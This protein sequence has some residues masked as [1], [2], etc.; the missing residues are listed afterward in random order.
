MTFFARS[1]TSSY[2]SQEKQSPQ[3]RP[4]GKSALL[5]QYSQLSAC[6]I[7]PAVP[8]PAWCSVLWPG[9]VR[10]QPS[11]RAG[12]RR[13]ALPVE[14]PQLSEQPQVSLLDR[15]SC[16]AMVRKCVTLW[17]LLSGFTRWKGAYKFWHYPMEMSVLQLL[18]SSFVLILSSPPQVPTAEGWEPKN[19]GVSC[20]NST[21]SCV[22]VRPALCRLCS[23]RR[24]TRRK[25]CLV[26]CV[27][28]AKDLLRWF[29]VWLRLFCKPFEIIY[30]SFQSFLIFFDIWDAMW[31]LEKQ[32]R[33]TC[34]I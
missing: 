31:F 34:W 18:I 19:A 8:T 20:R 29:L 32:Q 21:T 12:P 13:G 24:K 26:S 15:R 11:V 27:Q 1:L 16:T 14:S 3:C 25:V 33:R 5:R 22:S 10:L 6:W 23:R 4:A 7:T 17:R 30:H 28:S 2:D 9:Q